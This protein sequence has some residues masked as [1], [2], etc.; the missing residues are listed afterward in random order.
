MTTNESNQN[1][2]SLQEKALLATEK[3]L[4]ETQKDLEKER[5]ESANQRTLNGTLQQELAKAQAE[6]NALKAT[7]NQGVL[8]A[9]ASATATGHTSG[10]F[11]L[12]PSIDGVLNFQD[13]VHGKLAQAIHA[14][15]IEPCF[16]KY[17]CRDDEFNGFHMGIKHKALIMGWT[18]CKAPKKAILDI[19]TGNPATGKFLLEHYGTVTHGDITRYIDTWNPQGREAQDDR[20][21]FECL[22]NSLSSAGLQVI[23]TQGGNDYFYKGQASGVLFLKVIIDASS[24]RT[25]ATIYKYKTQLTKLVPT[26]RE[27]KWDIARFNGHVLNIEANLLR[28]GSNAP[29]LIHPVIT[30]YLT[31]P[32][33]AFK[34]YVDNTV[35]TYEINNKQLTAKTFMQDCRLKY[36]TLKDKGEWNIDEN[37]VENSLIFKAVV[38]QCDKKYV[39]RTKDP[40]KHGHKRGK[41]KGKYRKNDKKIEKDGWKTQCPRAGEPTTIDVNGKKFHWCSLKTGAKH[42]GGC[43]KWTVHTPE[44]CLGYAFKPI[45]R[46]NP[47][48]KGGDEEKKQKKKKS[49]LKV[50]QATMAV[51]EMTIDSDS[52]SDME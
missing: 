51:D 28:N 32:A 48:N 49:E 38:A 31:C 52:D 5:H 36:Q 15:G 39:R 2:L 45:P 46:K 8:A 16:D 12:V 14:K 13:K 40:S 6:L 26:I 44:Q 47:K 10:Q 34:D 20:I 1:D 21:L 19:P 4:D 30:A 22:W 33:K 37:D 18:A 9:N 3:A 25:N 50:K 27:M 42:P 41:E 43:N 11:T 7:Q 23:S 17:S 24:L 35:S 29:D